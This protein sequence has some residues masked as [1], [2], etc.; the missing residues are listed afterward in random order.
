[1]YLDFTPL[2][3]IIYISQ[4]FA[5]KGYK[6]GRTPYISLQ[7]LLSLFLVLQGVE[8]EVRDG[9]G[10]GGGEGDQQHQA[11]LALLQRHLQL[12]GVLFAQVRQVNLAPGN[13]ILHQTLVF[14]TPAYLHSAG[15]KKPP[16]R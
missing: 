6:R 15:Q 13:R 10:G 11:S 3:V 4:H 9:D 7:D 12:V 8:G 1:M 14:F 2:T 16:N 5:S